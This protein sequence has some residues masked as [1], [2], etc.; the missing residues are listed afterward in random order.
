VAAAERLVQKRNRKNYE[1]F[2][3]GTGQGHTVLEAIHTFE[4]TTGVNVKMKIGPR[5]PGDVEKVWADTTLANKELGWKATLS[6]EDIMRSAWKW[7]EHLK[8]K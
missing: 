5:R 3:L 8:N 7:E 1:V 4:K 2:N 6:L